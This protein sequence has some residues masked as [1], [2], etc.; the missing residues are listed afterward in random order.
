[1]VK[2]ATTTTTTTT[3]EP[4]VVPQKVEGKKAEGKKAEGKKDE[5]KKADVKKSKAEVAA[6]ATATATATETATETE[7][8]ASVSV[9]TGTKT[10][11]MLID[12]QAQFQNIQS[13][14]NTLKG[15]IKTL[16]RV[17]AKEMKILEKST[18]RN[19]KK[20]AGTRQPSGFVKPTPISDE[21]AKFL[22]KEKGIEMART[23]VT[24]EINAYIRAHSLQDK[25]NGRQ[26][27]ADSK[28][29]N[30]LKL[31][32]TDVLTYFNLQRYMSKH[33]PK[34]PSSA[35]ASASATNTV[36]AN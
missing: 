16:S 8:D 1:M 5:G 3:T 26:I 12:I 22:N 28:L 7:T 6:T 23:D 11:S 15:D 36:V 14:M 24:R 20:S 34:T 17:S 4:A 27:N 10:G 29:S 2:K 35:S 19:R 18:G 30:L 25:A 9:A 32:K 21:L 13:F 33:F 31:D